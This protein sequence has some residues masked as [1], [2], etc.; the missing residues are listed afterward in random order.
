MNEV[1]LRQGESVM[2]ADGAFTAPFT[3]MYTVGIRGITSLETQKEPE[4]AMRF[5]AGKLP[6]DELDPQ[7]LEEMFAV[8]SYGQKKYARMNWMKGAPATQYFGCIMR[9]LLKWYK[10]EDIDEE[11]GCTHLG[12]IACNIMMCMYSLRTNKNN[13]DDRP[14][15]GGNQ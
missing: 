11:S 13:N 3:G 14:F 2:T 8:I 1:Y 10:G 12:H 4:Q 15:K 7:F 9:H 6:L 5:T